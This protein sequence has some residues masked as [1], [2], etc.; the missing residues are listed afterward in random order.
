MAFS[1]DMLGK[2]LGYGFLLFIFLGMG[3]Y[4]FGIVKK[5]LREMKKREYTKRAMDRIDISFPLKLAKNDKEIRRL[6]ENSIIKAKLSRYEVTTYQERKRKNRAKA[7]SEQ[8]KEDKKKIT[9]ENKN[10]AE[11]TKEKTIKAWGWFK[12]IFTRKNTR[13]DSEGRSGT[14][15]TERK[16]TSSITERKR[17]LPI[18]SSRGIGKDKRKPEYIEQQRSQFN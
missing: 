1:Y 17:I 14:D 12:R 2:G 4:L 8:L 16:P 11:R 13:A 18:P 15:G 3:Y 9:E 7:K 6:R 5:Y 10:V